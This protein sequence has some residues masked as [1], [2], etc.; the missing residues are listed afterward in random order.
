L[1]HLTSS[2]GGTDPHLFAASSAAQVP[3]E[4]VA[5]HHD[6]DSGL[7]AIVAI[8]DSRRGPA[9]GG[10]RITHYGST[11]AALTDALRLSEGMSLKNA[12][13]DLPFGGGKAVII[14]P[15]SAYNRRAL[16]RAFGSV[17]DTKN[18]RYITA[19]DVGT[20]EADMQIITQRT[21][22]VGGLSAPGAQ[23]GNPAPQTAYGVWV[24]MQAGVQRVLRLNSLTGLTVAIQ[25]LGS[26]GFRLAELVHEAGAKLIV[27]DIDATAT[28]RAASELDAQVVAVDEILAMPCDVLAPCAMGAVLGKLSIPAL[29]TQLVCGAANNQL[30]TAP[31]GQRLK[32]RGVTY[33][34]DFLVNAGGII[35]AGLG[36]LGESSDDVIQRRIEQIEGRVH[37]LIRASDESGMDTHLLAER[38]AR[39]RLREPRPAPREAADLPA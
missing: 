2:I 29:R 14:E 30:V 3:H 36:Y 32:D 8:H 19:P 38:W 39:Q 24:A 25:G 33:L 20:T 6:R 4:H 7:Q 11:Q 23:G 12:L 21:Q 9:F 5:F 22:Y 35:S 10:C 17:V 31:D 1:S 13:A 16:M 26:V 34:P 18:G 37:D 28:R 15:S 27:A